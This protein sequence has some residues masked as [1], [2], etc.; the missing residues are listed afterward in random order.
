MSDRFM[1]RMSVLQLDEA[2][3]RQALIKAR[4]DGEVHLLLNRLQ[5]MEKERDNA[6]T[7]AEENSPSTVN[8]AKED[9]EGLELQNENLKREFGELVKEVKV[10]EGNVATKEKELGLLVDRVIEGDVDVEVQKI[11]RLVD[12]ARRER[13]SPKKRW[14]W[15]SGG[16]GEA[17]KSE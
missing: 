12:E 5:Q 2:V 16:L 6:V 15:L 8:R 7:E 3:K 14:Q 4:K 9:N 11:D 17:L 10:L 13:G 1:E